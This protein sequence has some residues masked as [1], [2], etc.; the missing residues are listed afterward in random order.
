MGKLGYVIGLSAK[1]KRVKSFK[2]G[3]TLITSSKR[4]KDNQLLCG[5]SKTKKIQC[6][7]GQLNISGVPIGGWSMC[8]GHGGKCHVAILTYLNLKALLYGLQNPH[9]GIETSAILDFG[10]VSKIS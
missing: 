3:T 2:N 1:A 10:K 5:T 4:K 8:I 7:H 9:N 6:F